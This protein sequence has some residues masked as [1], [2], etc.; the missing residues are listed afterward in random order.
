MFEKYTMVNQ[1]NNPDTIVKLLFLGIYLLLLLNAAKYGINTTNTIGLITFFVFIL[2]FFYRPA[3]S[4]RYQFYIT[5]LAIIIA[6]TAIRLYLAFCFYGNYDMESYDIVSDLV[7]HGQNV[8][9]ETARYNYSP[10]WFNILGILKVVSSGQPFHFAVRA[11]LTC[12]DLL[13]LLVLVSIAR[14]QKISY[15]GLIA[16]GL[17]FYLNPVSYL[18]TGYHGQFDNLALLFILIGMYLILTN[19][20]KSLILILTSWL[21]FSTGLIIKHIVLG[22]YL[23]GINNLVK[24]NFYRL[25]AMMA[26]LVLFLLSFLP[27][28]ATG[29]E[30]IIR[31]V[32]LYGA[33]PK[34]YGVSSVVNLPILKYVF[35]AGLCLYPFFIDDRDLITQFLLV[36]LF[37]LA[38]TTGMGIQFF[39]LPVAFGA[40]RQSWWFFLYSFTATVVLLGSGVNMRLAGFAAITMNAVWIVVLFWFVF[41]HFNLHI[42][43]EKPVQSSHQ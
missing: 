11:F 28:W 24:K 41:L 3:F 26:T 19:K 8:Y 38:F 31:N 4:S 5:F 30:G 39:I 35:I 1:L 29:S 2:L 34:M 12:I 25:L 15:E 21:A 20:N 32:F 18:I 23:T 9:N 16:V 33:I 14:L 17:L 43:Q 6:G 42:K 27:Y 22:H 7:V 13:I 10:I 36:S 40:L 37:F